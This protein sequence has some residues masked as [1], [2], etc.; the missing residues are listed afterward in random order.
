[1]TDHIHPLAIARNYQ[2]L[3]AILRARSDEL[4]MTREATDTE[5]G[6]SSG[7]A[8]KLLA[9]T[10]IRSFGPSS[11][12]P[13]LSLFGLALAVVEDDEAMDRFKSKRRK[14]T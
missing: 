1:M 11:L 10:P 14:A 12:G 7:Y 9:P 8:G 5:G 6:L 4:E 2:E 3:H 13:L